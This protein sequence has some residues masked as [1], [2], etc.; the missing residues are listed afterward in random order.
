MRNRTTLP[1]TPAAAFVFALASSPPLLP[2]RTRL[3][4]SRP[5]LPLRLRARGEPSSLPSSDDETESIVDEVGPPLL[6]RVRRRRGD[7]GDADEDVEEEDE[8]AEALEAVE[9]ADEIEAASLVD[10]AELVV[11]EDELFESSEASETPPKLEARSGL[12]EEA[13]GEGAVRPLSRVASRGGRGGGSWLGFE[14]EL[15]RLFMVGG[16]EGE[17][18][19]DEALFSSGRG[20]RMR[21]PPKRGLEVVDDVVEDEDEEE[22]V[23]AED[24]LLFRGERRIKDVDLDEGLSGGSSSGIEVLRFVFSPGDVLSMRIEPAN[25]FIFRNSA[26]APLR[27]LR[28][29]FRFR[30]FD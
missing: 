29:L 30:S 7:E 18:E 17:D 20:G 26:R 19:G 2:A 25:F 9:A 16:V 15:V 24:I 28:S 3:R 22:V 12:A 10:E 8:D 1:P 11:E 21:T 4:S 27:R 6:L 13:G 23:D 5:P 14:V